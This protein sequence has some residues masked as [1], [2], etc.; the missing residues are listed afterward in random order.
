[1]PRW[2]SQRR[3]I[4]LRS[5]RMS[6]ALLSIRIKSFPA[7]FIFVKRSMTVILAAA[8]PVVMS[9]NSRY[10]VLSL[11][12]GQRFLA[13]AR[14][15]K[16]PRRRTKISVPPIASSR[17]GGYLFRREGIGGLRFFYNSWA[18]AVRIFRGGLQLL[19]ARADQTDAAGRP[20]FCFALRKDPVAIFGAF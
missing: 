2:R 7:P 9:A 19:G 6:P 16:R 8:V 11:G 14:D 12:W 5:R 18:G 20:L 15:K 1:M 17:F 10:L 3:A 4:W 13:L